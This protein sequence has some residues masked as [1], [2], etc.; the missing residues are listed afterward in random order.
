ML[1]RNK[2]KLIVGIGVFCI[3][4]DLVK[5]VSGNM[6]SSL[7]AGLGVGVVIGFI[8]GGILDIFSNR[9]SDAKEVRDNIKDIN[10]KL[11]RKVDQDD[12]SRLERLSKLKDEN[13]ISEEEY[14]KLK[15]EILNN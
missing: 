12:I 3:Y 11:G 1:K 14:N 10:V 4:Y 15:A 7:L 8:V 5:F 13:H 9:R 2:F 6:L